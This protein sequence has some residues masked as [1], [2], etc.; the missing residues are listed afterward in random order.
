MRAVFGSIPYPDRKEIS[1]KSPKPTASTLTA[2]EIAL[3]ATPHERGKAKK[4]RGSEAENTRNPIVI[5]LQWDM[6]NL[7]L[8]KLSV[9]AVR[10]AV[11]GSFMLCQLSPLCTALSIHPTLWT[12]K[13]CYICGNPLTTKFMISY[14]ARRG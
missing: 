7:Y 14:K 8:V 9:H 1:R 12:V 13:L 11:C 4:N 2:S 10:G 5:K 3:R 6:L